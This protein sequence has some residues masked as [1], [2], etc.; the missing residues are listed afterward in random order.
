MQSSGRGVPY[1]PSRE[2]VRFQALGMDFKK[3][4]IFDGVGPQVA[5]KLEKGVL[6]VLWQDGLVR[7]CR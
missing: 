4:A 7:H 3:V 2:G 6:R 1:N 5:V